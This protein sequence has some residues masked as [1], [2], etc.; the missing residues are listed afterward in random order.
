MKID[1]TK[2]DGYFNGTP[3]YVKLS[4]GNGKSSLQLKIYEKLLKA[5]AGIRLGSCRDA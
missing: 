5:G 1:R 3:V 4:R 2:P